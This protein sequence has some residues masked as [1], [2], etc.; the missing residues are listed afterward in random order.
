M[1]KNRKNS[2]PKFQDE[3]I[4]YS[5]QIENYHESYC[6]G[7]DHTQSYDTFVKKFKS[8]LLTKTNEPMGRFEHAIITEIIYDRE[9]IF[10]DTATDLRELIQ[11]LESWACPDTAPKEKIDQICGPSEITDTTVTSLTGFSV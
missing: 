11:S 7:F 3:N 8:N 6:T 5:T 4:R 2:K 10:D 9:S 1:L